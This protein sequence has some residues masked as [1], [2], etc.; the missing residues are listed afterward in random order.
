MVV[1]LVWVWVCVQLLIVKVQVVVSNKCEVR[2]DNID[3][4]LDFFLILVYLFIYWCF[5]LCLKQVGLDVGIKFF[6]FFI[7]WVLFLLFFCDFFGGVKI[8]VEYGFGLGIELWVQDY[9]IDFLVVDE[10]VL[11]EVG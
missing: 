2:W 8:L 4:K 6:Y 11:V 7:D 5:L 10:V 9:G 3:C 1:V